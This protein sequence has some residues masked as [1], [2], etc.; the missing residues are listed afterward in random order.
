[1]ELSKKAVAYLVIV[2]IIISILTTLYFLD[3]ITKFKKAP[4]LETSNKG[5]ISLTIIKPSTNE[6]VVK[7]SNSSG[8]V[9]LVI[10]KPK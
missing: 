5:Q 6:K 2:L 4:K 3:S 7:S 9:A 1:M 8:Q 10:E